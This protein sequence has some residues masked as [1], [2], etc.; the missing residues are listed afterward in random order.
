MKTGS[1]A[2]FAAH[3][4]VHKS[5]VSRWEKSG[6]LVWLDDKQIDFDASDERIE[7]TAD[8]AKRGVVVRHQREREAKLIDAELFKPALIEEQNSPSPQAAASA[9]ASTPPPSAAS[10]ADATYAEFNRARADKEAELALLARLKREEQEGLVIRR[11]VIA[12]DIEQLAV[13]VSK[14]LDSIAARIMPLINAEA[15]PG[16]REALLQAELFKVKTEF[17][18]FALALGTE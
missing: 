3:R 11:D 4:G 7:Q 1:R 13:M 12:R 6:K 2:D 14:G 16:K 15:D 10:K 8:P 17:A 18:E 5:T 9:V